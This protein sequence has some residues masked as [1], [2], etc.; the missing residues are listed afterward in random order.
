MFANLIIALRRGEKATADPW[1]G[2]TLEWQVPS[3]P[4]HENF[5]EIPVIDRGA[6]H[7]D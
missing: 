1:G 3:P 4:P 2:K 7:Y 5:D 6:Y